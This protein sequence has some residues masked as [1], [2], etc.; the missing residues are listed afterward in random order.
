MAGGGYGNV[1]W[2]SFFGSGGIPGG[3]EN[4]P[5]TPE[6]DIF[7]LGGVQRI[8]IDRL[9]D[10]IEVATFGGG[11][12]FFISSWNMCSGDA[13]PDTL[14]Y[15]FFDVRVT[16]TFTVEYNVKF[17]NLPDDFSDP[18]VAHMYLGAW[19]SQ[20]FA[21]GFLFSKA[22][23]A[24]TGEV[25]F[26][27]GSLIYLQSI[28][29]IP[30]SSDWFPDVFAEGE[31]ITIRV[32]V[33]STIP[34]LYLF[35]TKTA[36]LESTGHVLRALLQPKETTPSVP[37]GVILAVRG[38]VTEQVCIE[39][40]N[41][42]RMSSKALI[43]NLAPVAIAGEDQA[44]RICSI[45]RLD[46]SES[47]DPEGEELTYEWR[48]IDAP[49]PSEFV[50]SSTDGVTQS[51]PA[52]FTNDFFS[53]ALGLEHAREP[54]QVNDV[55]MVAGIGYTIK[56]INDVVP[57]NV[58][59][60]YSQLVTDQAGLK[61]KLVR[62]N[63]INTR[64]SEKPTFF[65]DV[66]GFFIFD[67]RVFDGV[68]W[69]SPL[70]L[71]RSR[72]LLDVRESPLPRACNVNTTFVFDSLGSF[73]KQVEDRDRIT[74]IWDG[75]AQATAS[76]LLG[77]WQHEYGK[78]LRDIQRQF[79]VRWLHYDLLL[80]EPVPEL[81]QLKFIWGGVLSSLFVTTP[82]AGRKIV[83][84]TPFTTEP[85]EV[86]LSGHGGVPPARL[87]AELDTR[88]RD[89]VDPRFSV[90][91]LE[92]EDT[93]AGG[94]T[95]SVVDT[96]VPANNNIFRTI[97]ATDLVVAGVLAGDTLTLYE[98][99]GTSADYT[100][101]GFI[102]VD[103]VTITTTFPEAP[104]SSV[105]FT[106]RRPGAG[107]GH[108]QITAPFYFTLTTDSDLAVFSYPAVNTIPVGLGGV[109]LSSKVLKVDVPLPELAEDDLLVIGD[110]SYRI[111]EVIS[112]S[113]DKFDGQRILVKDP[114]PELEDV[115]EWSVPGW[116]SSELLNFYNGLIFR[117]DV[118]EFESSQEREEDRQTDQTTEMITTAAMG[119]NA[120]RFDRLAI[121]TA[122]L[123]S[124]LPTADATARLARI[125]RRRYVP[126]DELVV[127]V[128]TLQE[129][130]KIE[131]DEET[132]RRN[133]D[134]FLEEFR[135]FTC[136]RFHA[137]LPTDDGDV[138]E[139]ERPPDRLWAEYTYIN[140]EPTIENNFGRPIG[141]L[142]E[143]VPD[144]VDYLS[145]VQGLW[146]SRY[147]GPT[148]RNVRI[149]SQILLG[150]PF[151]EVAGEI[152][153]IRDEFLSQRARLLI[154][155]SDNPEIT[156]SYSYPNILDREINPETGE[157]YALGDA[158]TQ[159]APL[160][161]GVEVT[162]YIKDPTWFEGILNQGIFYEVQ[163]Y[164]TFVVGVDTEAFTLDALLATQRFV[165]GLKPMYTDPKF[166]VGFNVSGDG[167]EIDVIDRIEYKGF[168]TIDQVPCRNRTASYR[169]DE[170]WDSGAEF[171][172]I[173][174]NTGGNED[175]RL[176]NTWR[177]R[178][179]T[180]DASA[181]VGPLPTPMVPDSEVQWAY[182]KGGYV[183]PSDILDM[184]SCQEFLAST[185]MVYDS[186]F[187]Y[188]VGEVYDPGGPLE[189]FGPSG[190]GA[191]LLLSAGSPFSIP[192]AGFSVTVTP[193]SQTVD[194]TVRHVRIS[195]LGHTDATPDPTPSV[196]IL[197][198]TY[199]IEI[200]V[201]SVMASGFPKT[202]VLN[203][204]SEVEYVLSEAASA[205]DVVEVR[206]VS[207]SGHGT[208]AP[209][210]DSITG[211]VIYD[212]AA[213][214][215]DLGE[216]HPIGGVPPPPTGS[217]YPAGTYCAVFKVVE[218]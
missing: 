42:Y 167:D 96:G 11:N 29:I 206:V 73:W 192:E 155:D 127:D 212:F 39:V 12:Q 33:D 97:P 18:V 123:F 195:F 130:I 5:T 31:D 25:Q 68:L 147:N 46:G 166:I 126:M 152:V 158:V 148:L 176:A 22:G 13:F 182:D 66:T 138:W 87:A 58:E 141:V 161:E 55:L 2:G 65:P 174:G 54:I 61:Y 140:N 77:V 74:A 34:V 26:G 202:E 38:T 132:L 207:P 20:D 40:I 177:N 32:V 9:T 45:G 51:D 150:L 48:L 217:L 90:E 199:E 47:F 178:Y 17:N 112:S 189:T 119:A 83:V 201:N 53:S 63:G 115:T 149:A 135:G 162:D 95:G 7:D 170:P 28:D 145:A 36:E 37:E 156:R 91:A 10:F 185:P 216:T 157:R 168:L 43:P 134:Y 114:L 211:F 62:Q 109:R 191:K 204:N 116:V 35:I 103:R 81:S 86:E 214:E 133:V 122:T 181:I 3:L 180:A 193:S 23:V 213:W 88:L 100:V 57:F 143:D 139:G 186:I 98:D 108:V 92:V 118:V 102:G 142:R 60:E 16:E 104:L 137:G 71:N 113:V 117:G 49:E 144:G 41:D 85:V 120:T 173:I 78:S 94:D 24:Y 164:H 64:E 136:L 50:F 4:I 89:Q 197:N 19:S 218:A 153:E 183:C 30:G 187:S 15:T 175:Y 79:I 44:L 80:P 105:R 106:I 21:A 121:D 209:D 172:P 59:I 165:H 93:L 203:I 69:S 1:P 154:Q 184:V 190:P 70:G 56:T 131:D 163:K 72:V 6:W 159:F 76:E 196:D 101:S 27:G 111:S 146:Y 128:P 169:Y 194:G 124:N 14:A 82:V 210:W 129:L 171:D 107:L 110:E 198:R 160:V 215:Y 8:D 205:S 99:D 188:D 151:A 208:K 84:T 179:D 125:I 200:L 75:L 52:G 67:L